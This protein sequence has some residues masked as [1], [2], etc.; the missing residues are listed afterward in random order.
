MGI[1]RKTDDERGDERERTMEDRTYKTGESGVGEKT[2]TNSN[3]QTK[4]VKGLIERR[5]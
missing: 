5:R 1:K 2:K 3:Q 4:K